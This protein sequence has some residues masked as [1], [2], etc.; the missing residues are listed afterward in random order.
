MA[1]ASSFEIWT[2]NLA[3]LLPVGTL[4]NSQSFIFGD[5]NW[6]FCKISYPVGTLKPDIQMQTF[7]TCDYLKNNY[8]FIFE[9]KN[10]NLLHIQ[11]HCIHKLG[12]IQSE[13]KLQSGVYYWFLN[14]YTWIIWHSYFPSHG[15]SWR[16]SSG[17]SGAKWVNAI[18]M[19][20]IF[21][22]NL[23]RCIFGFVVTI[24][25]KSNWHAMWKAGSV[26][27]P[28][29]LSFSWTTLN[30]QFRECIHM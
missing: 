9:W 6:K 14:L 19:N 4:T 10:Q 15:I 13:L 24:T 26:H 27:I 29:K 22:A 3:Q 18:W 30:S 17:W 8:A 20:N 2:A 23:H 28:G 16:K 21:S 11:E 5:S 1:P 12:K 7:L 25:N